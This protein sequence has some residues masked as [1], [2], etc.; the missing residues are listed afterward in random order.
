VI[1]HAA[2]AHNVTSYCAARLPTGTPADFL[3]ETSVVEQRA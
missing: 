3:N 2:L 1:L